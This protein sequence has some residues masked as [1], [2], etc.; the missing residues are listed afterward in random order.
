MYIMLLTVNNKDV[1]MIRWF[2]RSNS[3]YLLI[4]TTGDFYWTEEINLKDFV[5]YKHD[6]YINY[7]NLELIEQIGLP[8]IKKIINSFYSPNPFV[9]EWMTHIK[10]FLFEKKLKGLIH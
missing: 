7:Y 2:P 6:T 5:P 9:N 8:E 10:N 3:N 4:L 1:F